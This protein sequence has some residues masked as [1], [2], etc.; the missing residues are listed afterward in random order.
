MSADRHDADMGVVQPIGGANACG[1]ANAGGVNY[2]A[3]LA[4]YLAATILAEYGYQLDAAFPPGMPLRIGAEQ[5]WPIDALALFAE[6]GIGWV[7]A[8]RTVD[9]AALRESLAQ[10]GRQD[11]HGRGRSGSREP[12]GPD[13]RFILAFEHAS[14]WI[15]AQLPALLDRVRNGASF[16]EM[17][18]ESE[19]ARVACEKELYDFAYVPFSSEVH[20]MWNAIAHANLRRCE[21]PLHRF[22]L[23]PDLQP[24]PLT[25]HA[26][27]LVA[28]I[29]DRTYR[30]WESS[31][32]LE[33]CGELCLMISATR[34]RGC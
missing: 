18:Q 23:V 24:S 28:E 25:I 13:D 31:T 17:L 34:S 10:F 22:H 14:D 29:M 7:Q 20:G 8:K 26:P 4:T 32:T 21:E 3:A 30:A 2:Q 6:R 11:A 33:L 27:L 16:D 5:A 19:P 15:E 9:R 12:L 1:A